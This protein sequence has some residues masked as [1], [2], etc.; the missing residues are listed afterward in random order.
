MSTKLWWFGLISAITL[1]VFAQQKPLHGELLL[2]WTFDES[3]TGDMDVTNRG[4]L[5]P[6]ANGIFSGDA[7]RTEATPAD[8]SP[9]AADLLFP[10]N[11]VVSATDSSGLD[12]LSAIT[13]SA[14]INLQGDPPADG[15]GNDRIVALQDGTANF[16]G[17]SFNIN[18]P[19]FGGDYTAD[20][21]RLGMFIGGTDQ[22]AFAQADD[23]IFGFAGEWVFVAT[24]YDSAEPFDNMVFYWGPEVD[25]VTELGFP[26]TVQAGPIA[27][28]EAGTGF[29][30]GKTDAAPD[31]N[32]SIE[33]WIDDVRIYDEALTLE[34]LQ[35]IRMENLV[36]PPLDLPGDYD[37]DLFVGQGDIDLVLLNWGAAVSG[38]PPA[39]WTTNLPTG[40]VDQDELDAVLLN[41]GTSAGIGGAKGVPEPST[42]VLLTFLALP[43]CAC[44]R[45]KVEYK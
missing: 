19:F 30:V 16:N 39:G 2:Q 33:G 28:V 3:T 43:L 32:T 11:G 36:P 42:I 26:F 21:F 29:H 10:G 15:S 9:A 6:A 35:A 20:N 23:D 41:W 13:V 18:S 37:D 22:F 34:D 4:S 8:A 45:R 12:G 24:T 25:E 1:C 38:G 7:T 17:F 40:S 44:A 14:W 5:G 27:P 31:A